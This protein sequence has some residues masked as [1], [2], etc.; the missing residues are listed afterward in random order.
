[1]ATP[2]NTPLKGQRFESLEE[3]QAYLDR[4]E[5]HWADTRIHGTIKRQV[6]VMFAEEKPTLTPLPLEPFRRYQ[7]GERRVRRP[8]WR[9]RSGSRLLQRAAQAGWACSRQRAVGQPRRTR[10]LDPR[11]GQLLREHLRQQRGGHPG[12]PMKTSPRAL[13]APPRNCSL[14]APGSARISARSLQIC[15]HVRARQPGEIRRILGI[16]SLARQHGA[17]LLPMMRAPRHWTPASRPT[18]IASLTPLAGT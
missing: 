13:R 5:A 17:L 3:A 11:S 15:Q 9:R 4:W 14:A 12:F 18:L 16:T 6:G 2:K 8:R 1:M 10:V 7:F